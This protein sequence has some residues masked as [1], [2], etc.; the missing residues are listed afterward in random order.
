M[1]KK[2]ASTDVTE[3]GSAELDQEPANPRQAVVLDATVDE[4]VEEQPD[5]LDRVE[6]PEVPVE[7]IIPLNLRVE[8]DSSSSDASDAPAPK[9]K[10]ADHNV[11]MADWQ[12]DEMA[13]KKGKPKAKGEVRDILYR[14]RM[15]KVNEP[16]RY[17]LR[18]LQN[19]PHG[20]VFIVGYMPPWVSD[21]VTH[22][23]GAKTTIKW[24]AGAEQFRLGCEALRG[25][26]LYLVDDDMFIVNPIEEIGPMHAG[27]LANAAMNKIGAYGRT[28][29]S[30]FEYLAEV[31]GMD[32]PLSY[33]R[34]VPMPLD[35]SEAADAITE[36]QK[37]GRTLQARSIYGNVAGIG[38]ERVQDVKYR[39]GQHIAGDFL[40]VDQATWAR[41]WARAVK[42]MF[43]KPSRYERR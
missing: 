39:P 30:T 19:I 28:F 4:L 18:S 1:A 13:S 8:S 3:D 20:E 29:K 41:G 21:E 16:L 14:V 37:W 11:H 7:P 27:P 31:L 24:R 12:Q 40:S 25:R 43:P 34:H 26:K 22:I 35:A 42:A 36:A 32:N 23:E 9:G 2:K 38:G 17:S 33:E 15:G 5:T 10:A 6:V